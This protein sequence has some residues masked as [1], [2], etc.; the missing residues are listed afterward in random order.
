[1]TTNGQTGTFRIH[2]DAPRVAIG[3]DPHN[4]PR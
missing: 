2:Q 3:F 1:V 4:C